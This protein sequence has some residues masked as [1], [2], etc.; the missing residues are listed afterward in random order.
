[1]SPDKLKLLSQLRYKL[2]IFLFLLLSGCQKAD[3]QYNRKYCVSITS[4]QPRHS[5]ETSRNQL[6]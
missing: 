2:I 5:R 4:H 1:M 6:V 3:A